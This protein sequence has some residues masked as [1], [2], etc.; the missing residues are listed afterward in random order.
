MT[1]LLWL[2]DR[3]ERTNDVKQPPVHYDLAN[4]ALLCP[5]AARR[6]PRKMAREKAKEDWSLCYRID[7]QSSVALERL[8]GRSISCGRLGRWYLYSTIC[9]CLCWL[10]VG[11]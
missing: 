7:I 10:H 4:L 2:Q 11:S 8:G 5:A 1:R 6:G 9:K 3:N